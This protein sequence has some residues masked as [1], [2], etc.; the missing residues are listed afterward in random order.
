MNR[1]HG[2]MARIA[3]RC[4]VHN[5]FISFS[6]F[7][8]E[9][10]IFDYGLTGHFR[11]DAMFNAWISN[12]FLATLVEKLPFYGID[13][14]GKM[15]TCTQ[16]SAKSLQFEGFKLQMPP[17]IAHRMCLYDSNSACS[18]FICI[19]GNRFK[20]LTNQSVWVR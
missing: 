1:Q 6:S 18:L 2:M 5:D 12:L 17:G 9:L 11:L 7:Q 16:S 14:M 4:R 15:I 3:R 19:H 20:I 8:C 10:C 13:R